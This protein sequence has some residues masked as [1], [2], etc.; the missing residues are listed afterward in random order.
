MLS[1][2][3]RFICGSSLPY[4]HLQITFFF[5]LITTRDIRLKLFNF[6]GSQTHLKMSTRSVMFF[7]SRTLGFLMGCDPDDEK[8]EEVWDGDILLPYDFDSFDDDPYTDLRD[9]LS[10]NIQLGPSSLLSSSG[11]AT[12]TINVAPVIAKKVTSDMALEDQQSSE[13]VDEVSSEPVKPPDIDNFP[14][15]T[16]ETC[17]TGTGDTSDI[18]ANIVESLGI[19]HSMEF[20]SDLDVKEAEAEKEVAEVTSE[21]QQSENITPKEVTTNRQQ[22]ENIIPKD[23][24]TNRQK[25]ENITLNDVT[26]NSQQ[27]GA[28]SFE[29]NSCCPEAISDDDGEVEEDSSKLLDYMSICENNIV[30]YRSDFMTLRP[31]AYVSDPIVNF[32]LDFLHRKLPPSLQKDVYIFPSWFYQVLS[33]TG[34]VMKPPV[35]IFDKGCKI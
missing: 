12:S 23:V 27:G 9:L 32:Y 1:D 21:R 11:P 34:T 15:D 3:S 35:N 4:K 28:V 22:S 13:L 20:V 18:L 30:V 16:P 31:N 17:V 10:K 6:Q 7:N 8:D 2:S 29:E 26:N 5:L 14:A 24:T 19:A 33:T 25:S